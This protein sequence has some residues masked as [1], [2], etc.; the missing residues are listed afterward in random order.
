MKKNKLFL[1][2]FL[3]SCATIIHAQDDLSV[4]SSYMNLTP[5]K[6]FCIIS[7]SILALIMVC[8]LVKIYKDGITS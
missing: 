4:P 5:A 8:G 1:T 7:L 2:L 6:L 3:I